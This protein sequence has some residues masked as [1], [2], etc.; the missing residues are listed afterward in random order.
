MV[1]VLNVREPLSELIRAALPSVTVPCHTFV[2]LMLRRAPS[3]EIPVPLSVRASA[4]TVMVFWIW[5]A[6]PPVTVVPAAVVP[7]AVAFWMFK[8]PA[9]TVVRPV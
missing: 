2:P 5:S 7:S 4:P 1:A 6:A 8:T 9:V 3:E